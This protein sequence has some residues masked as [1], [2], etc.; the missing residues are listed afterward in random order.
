MILNSSCNGFTKYDSTPVFF[1]FFLNLCQREMSQEIIGFDCPWVALQRK[2]Q[3]EYYFS[4]WPHCSQVRATCCVCSVYLRVVSKPETEGG[5]CYLGV[6]VGGSIPRY[7]YFRFTFLLPKSIFVSVGYNLGTSFD[8]CL[9]WW[10]H[11][12]VG[13]NNVWQPW[14]DWAAPTIRLC[15]HLNMNQRT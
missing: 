3:V 1:F 12:T 10:T 7:R 14:T 4:I 15:C 5:L 8:S 13:A 2:Q 9:L 11:R 6:W